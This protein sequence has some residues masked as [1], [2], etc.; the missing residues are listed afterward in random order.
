MN[1]QLITVLLRVCVSLWLVD[2]LGSCGVDICY[3]AKTVQ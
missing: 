1:D 2:F 3:S